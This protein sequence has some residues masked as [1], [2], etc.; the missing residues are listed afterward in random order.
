MDIQAI[1]NLAKQLPGSTISVSYN[2]TIN[3]APGLQAAKE[4]ESS[5]DSVS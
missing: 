3:I 4:E 2:T 5:D 1:A